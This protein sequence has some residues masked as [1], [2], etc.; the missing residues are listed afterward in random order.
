MVYHASTKDVLLFFLSPL[1]EQRLLLSAFLR[2]W[3]KRE[4]EEECEV[5]PNVEMKGRGGGEYWLTNG[6]V[7]LLGHLLALG[8]KLLDDV[9]SELCIT[10][11]AV[12]V[13]VQEEKNQHKGTSCHGKDECSNALPLDPPYLQ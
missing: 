6:G 10:P 11:C 3:R 8:F 4:R 2:G 13:C 9:L 5:W 12:S 1:Q 7:H